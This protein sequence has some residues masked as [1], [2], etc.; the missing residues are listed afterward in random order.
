[1]SPCVLFF[2]TNLTQGDSDFERIGIKKCYK[3]IR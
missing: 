1:M 3:A 2:Q